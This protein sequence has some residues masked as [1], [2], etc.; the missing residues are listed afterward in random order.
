MSTIAELFVRSIFQ[1]YLS[2]PFP[3]WPFGVQSDVAYSVTLDGITNKALKGNDAQ[4]VNIRQG[5]LVFG[6]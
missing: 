3:V 5:D 6:F 1:V 2:R 4:L